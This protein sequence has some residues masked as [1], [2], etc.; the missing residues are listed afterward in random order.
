MPESTR[1]GSRTSP[2]YT[3]TDSSGVKATDFPGG[4]A[5]PHMSRAWKTSIKDVASKQ[6]LS[7]VM[8]GRLP[9]GRFRTM[10]PTA[11]LLPIPPLPSVHG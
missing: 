9:E 8:E 6:G 3:A 11:T 1:S 5:L 7:E 4:I 10:H 2:Y